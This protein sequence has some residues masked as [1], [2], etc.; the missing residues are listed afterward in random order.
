MPAA[1]VFV[2]PTLI[3]FKGKSREKE[4]RVQREK[5]APNFIV[6]FYPWAKEYIVIL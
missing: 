2:R 4:M 5:F 3:R 6:S 1:M